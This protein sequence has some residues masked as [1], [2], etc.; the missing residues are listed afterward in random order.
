[1]EVESAAA[2]LP[3]LNS[4]KVKLNPNG[5]ELRSTAGRLTR[6]VLIVGLFMSHMIERRCENGTT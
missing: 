4:M 6:R 2:F 5:K 3:T 1:M